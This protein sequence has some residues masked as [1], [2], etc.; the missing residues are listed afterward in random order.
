MFVEKGDKWLAGRVIQNWL[1][2][3][4][5]GEEKLTEAQ[6]QIFADARKVVRRIEGK[7]GKKT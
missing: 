3:L 5:I 7:Y 2:S 6:K 4:E 1:Y